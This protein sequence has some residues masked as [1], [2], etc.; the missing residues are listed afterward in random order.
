[1]TEALA[2][3][4]CVPCRD[5]RF[6]SLADISQCNHHVCFTPKADIRTAQINFRLG[7]EADH[8]NDFV[9][10]GDSLTSAREHRRLMQKGVVV[11]LLDKEIRHVGARDETACPVTRIE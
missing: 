7:P 1:M 8:L 3:K 6:G 4:K 11:D 10:A 2:E 9:D 5:V